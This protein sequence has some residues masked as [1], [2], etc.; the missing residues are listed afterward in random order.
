[1]PI[2]ERSTL[3]PIFKRL[4]LVCGE[5]LVGHFQFCIRVLD[6]TY[7]ETCIRVSR[8][9][10]WAAGS[11]CLPSA[12]PIEGQSTFHLASVVRV[13]SKAVLLQKRFDLAMKKGFVGLL[14]RFLGERSTTCHK[15]QAK[16]E[17]AP[18]HGV[19]DWRCW[20]KTAC[21]LYRLE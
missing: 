21:P 12:P 8:E 13:A 19:S 20:I 1:L 5:L 15:Q 11:S 17:F 16:E 7:Q 4:D 6:G 10:R 14:Y 3:N 18:V 9:Y 2:I